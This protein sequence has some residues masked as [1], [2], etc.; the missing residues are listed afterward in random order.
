MGETVVD[1]DLLFIREEF[2]RW[3]MVKINLELKGRE[4]NPS[5]G[6]IWWAGCGKNLGSEINGKDARFARPVLVYKK[7]SRF[8][9]MGVPLTSKVHE[10]SWYVPFVQNGVAQVAIVGQAKIMSV[11]RLYSRMGKVDE[12][13][14]RRIK[15]AFLRLYS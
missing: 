9:F 5:Q 10:G 7:L 1:D 8:N 4:P 15:K 12:N 2:D 14:M 3:N 13:D 11:K 6:E